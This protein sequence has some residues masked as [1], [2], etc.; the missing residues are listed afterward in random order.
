MITRSHGLA[1]LLIQ[2]DEPGSIDLG[3]LAAGY[4]VDAWRGSLITVMAFVGGVDPAA[5]CL[6]PERRGFTV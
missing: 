3:I 4:G 6:I 5:L 2:M 1:P